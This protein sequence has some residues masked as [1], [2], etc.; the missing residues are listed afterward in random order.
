MYCTVTTVS[1]IS[2]TN[3]QK[4]MDELLMASQQLGSVFGA[5]QVSAIGRPSHGLVAATCGKWTADA[6]QCTCSRT[7]HKASKLYRWTVTSI[8]AS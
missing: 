1:M 2:E 8:R 4:G 6:R 5:G 7:H 3:K